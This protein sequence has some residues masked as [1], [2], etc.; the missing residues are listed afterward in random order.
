MKRIPILILAAA[1]AGPAAAVACGD[2][3]NAHNLVV[4]P[5]VRAAIARA[6]TARTGVTAA[7]VP[8]KTYYGSH[9][10]IQFAVATFGSRPAIF[11][12]GGMGRWRLLRL[13]HGGVCSGVVPVDLIRAWAMTHWRGGC[14]TEP[15]V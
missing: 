10:G 13:T 1:L 4:T 7:A 9:V 14:F 8:G 2:T 3:P 6:Y 5:Q 11:S 12:D 15:S